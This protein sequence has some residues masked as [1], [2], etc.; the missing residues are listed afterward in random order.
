MSSSPPVRSNWLFAILLMAALV[1]VVLGRVPG[2]VGVSAIVRAGYEWAL[3]LGGVALLLGVVN[4]LW[5]HIRRIALGQRDWVLSL[6]LIAVL[7]AVAGAGLLSP[8][9][10]ASPLLEWVFDAVIA[11]GQAAL[12][13]LLIFF[14]AAAA[15][16]YLRIGR[17]GGAWMLAGFLVIL[18]AQTPFIF[19]WLP[20]GSAGVAD[21]LL[22]APVMAALRGVL[23]GSSLALLIVGLRLLLGRP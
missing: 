17:R 8:T 10:A 9:G 3:L 5:L 7:I 11:P 13:A 14:M 16:Q 12:F 22:N 4:V 20:P 15:F 6:A 23:L 1:F 18:A 19:A 2:W 21:W